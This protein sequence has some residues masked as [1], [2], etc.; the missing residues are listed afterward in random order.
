MQTKKGI[1]IVLKT[2]FPYKQKMS[3]FDKTRGKIICVPDRN[4]IQPGALIS[5]QLTNQ[6]YMPFARTI[7]LIESPLLLA[8][9][10]IIFVHH[11][12]EVCY[13]FISSN[14]PAPEIF[15]LLVKLYHSETMLCD[16]R[17]KKIFLFILF[18]KL[19]IYPES[20]KFDSIYFR[21]LAIKF[22][23]RFGFEHIDLENEQLVN[24]W[25]Y[26]CLLMHP[27]F[28]YFKTVHFLSKNRAV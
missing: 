6:Q 23:D 4:D 8:R 19:G 5:Y 11:V 3:I 25:L 12:L 20:K 2:F 14:D 24:A 13:Y 27:C 21:N 28:N 18:W 9:E 10:D 15:D 1:G 16:D 22:V 26:E 7:N 17:N